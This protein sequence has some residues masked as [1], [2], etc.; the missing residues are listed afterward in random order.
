MVSHTKQ[1]SDKKEFIHT[2]QRGKALIQEQEQMDLGD[3]TKT[4]KRIHHVDKKMEAELKT[5]FRYLMTSEALGKVPFTPD[6]TDEGR[7]LEYVD[8]N[9]CLMFFLSGNALLTS[10]MSFG[11]CAF[12]NQIANVDYRSFYLH[13]AQFNSKLLNIENNPD[14]SLSDYMAG[15]LLHRKEF[16]EPIL[17]E[18]SSEGARDDFLKNRIANIEKANNLLKDVYGKTDT[19]KTTEKTTKKSTKEP[20]KE[21]IRE[22]KSGALQLNRLINLYTTIATFGFVCLR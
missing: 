3:F 16:P 1:I 7:F 5:T 2:Q 4:M 12:A 6:R 8:A 21:T 13:L 19:R 18:D 11:L 14:H 10:K 22:A 17:Q 15:L 20:A 9:L